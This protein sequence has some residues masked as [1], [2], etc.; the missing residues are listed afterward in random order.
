M[1]RKNTQKN[2]A[3]KSMEKNRHHMGVL[4]A[5]KIY[6]VCLSVCLLSVR[7]QVKKFGIPGIFRHYPFP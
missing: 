4:G 7:H 6:S 3:Q 1:M 2:V 5:K